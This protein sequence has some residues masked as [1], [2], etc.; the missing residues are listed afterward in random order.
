VGPD[1]KYGLSLVND[2]FNIRYASP[3]IPV[4]VLSGTKPEFKQFNPFH[5]FFF[6]AGEVFIPLLR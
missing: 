4:F 6:A 3:V 1:V 2:G 5:N